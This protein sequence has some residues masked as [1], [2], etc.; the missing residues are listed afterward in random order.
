M[1]LLILANTLASQNREAQA[2]DL[3]EYVITRDPDNV[4]AVRALC[5][6]YLIVGRYDDAL[7]MVARY[8]RT[9]SGTRDADPVTMVKGQ[10]LWELGRTKEATETMK[11]FLAGQ[12]VT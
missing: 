10:A 4:D 9:Q 7:D 1:V 8:E 12:A 2:A 5:G 3:L 11:K 6:I